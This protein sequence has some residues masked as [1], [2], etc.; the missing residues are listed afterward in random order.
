MLTV[1]DL[2]PTIRGMVRSFIEEIGSNQA[3]QDL[4]IR[5]YLNNGLR[6]LVHLAYI[7]K[8]SDPLTLN[9]DGDAVFQRSSQTITNM[10]APLR[11]LDPSGREIDKRTSFVGTKGWWRESAYTP[12][13][14]RGF[15][16]SSQPL[17]VGQYTLHYLAYPEQV[18]L[19]SS[20]VE[21]PQA[22]SMG[23][24]Y[25]VAALIMESLPGDKDLV[26][27]YMAVSQQ[28]LRI[29]AQANIDARG[30]GS[31]GFVPSLNTVDTV[32]DRGG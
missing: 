12:L 2:L 4:N 1:N 5:I 7:V 24:C 31:G 25:Y 9:A 18:A 28:H 17:P 10:Y 14:I 29:V 3:E 13:N 19:N 8:H 6:K 22:G 16:L 30:H 20:V 26:A 15:G 21:F 27:H 32:F 23:L 11:I